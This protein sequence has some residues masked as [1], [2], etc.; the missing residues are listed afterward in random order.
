VASSDDLPS[1][2]Q[3][4]QKVG[5]NP[6]L[7]NKSVNL[8]FRPPWSFAPEILTQLQSIAV[9]S[10]EKT[11]LHF[12]KNLSSSFWWSTSGAWENFVGFGK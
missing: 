6:Q 5:L 8:R 2:K 11:G 12:K 1:I 3:M 7:F 10:G 9:C 4:I